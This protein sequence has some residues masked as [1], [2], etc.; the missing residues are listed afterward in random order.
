MLTRPALTRLPR[1]WPYLFLLLETGHRT[2]SSLP[3]TGAPPR[4]RGLTLPRGSAFLPA[5]WKRVPRA[6]SPRYSSI[7]GEMIAGNNAGARVRAPAR[8]RRSPWEDSRASRAKSARRIHSRGS[9]ARGWTC[10]FCLLRKLGIS[11][12]PVF[13]FLI[14]F[15]TSLEFFVPSFSLLL[16]LHLFLLF[17]FFFS[18]IV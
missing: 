17:L 9:R 11:G 3:V 14:I 10:E 7:S 18:S 6:S 5:P 2:A 8:V 16:L 15:L 12:F 4:R 13:L 1:T